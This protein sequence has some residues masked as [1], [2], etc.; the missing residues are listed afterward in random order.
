MT[1]RRSGRRAG[2]TLI[3]V[4]VAVTVTAIFVGVIGQGLVTARLGSVVTLEVADAEAVARTL[5]AGPVPKAIRTPGS[6]LEGTLD[7]HAYVM[8][9]ELLALPLK[10]RQVG[11]KPPPEPAFQPLRLRVVVSAGG[12]RTVS[13]ETIRLAPRGGGAGS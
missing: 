1:A 13:V 8:T 9:S 11:D 10:P 7:G 3:E 5:M 4:L 12:S 6:R 2:F